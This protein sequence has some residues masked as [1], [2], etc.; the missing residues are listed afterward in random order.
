MRAATFT[1]D[2]ILRLLLALLI[3]G[4][5]GWEREC[6]RHPA[7]IRTHMLVTLGATVV[8]L[9]G[10]Q[11]SVVPGVDPTRLGAGVLSGIGF[12]GAGTI[13]KEGY[14]V[15]GLT[16]AASLWT[17]ACLG[18]AAGAGE[19]VLAVL[20]L[21]CVLATLLI[22]E[23]N[24][25]RLLHARRHS[26]VRVQCTC[27]NRT[28]LFTQFSEVAHTYRAD[29]SSLHVEPQADDQ[30]RISFVLHFDLRDPGP[31]INVLFESFSTIDGL[32]DID[33][34]YE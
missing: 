26:R 3:G 27:A 29:I 4:S 9:I 5:V 8:M 23:I 32:D 30:L 1:H 21:L 24:R 11:M 7:G 31:E 20:G 14:A 28:G 10:C 19:Y 2:I 15:T 16:T 12:L 18:L 34:S 25:K 13:M 33:L 17:V 6:N 22:S